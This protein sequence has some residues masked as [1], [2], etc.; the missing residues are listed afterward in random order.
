M[1]SGQAAQ[2]AVAAGALL[3]TGGML[4]FLARV[5]KSTQAVFDGEPQDAPAAEVAKAPPSTKPPAP[6][7]IHLN[8]GDPLPPATPLARPAANAPAGGGARNPVEMSREELTQEVISLRARLAH[9][10]AEEAAIRAALRAP[11][12]P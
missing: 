6:G 3:V 4:L 8:E 1:N 5:T 9:M 10:E 11:A 12:A 7:V 2:R